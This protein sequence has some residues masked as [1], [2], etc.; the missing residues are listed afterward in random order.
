MIVPKLVNRLPSSVNTVS[1]ERPF[2]GVEFSSPMAELPSAVVQTGLPPTRELRLYEVWYSDS[3]STTSGRHRDW[4]Y[5]YDDEALFAW[6]YLPQQGDLEEQTYHAYRTL[7]ELLDALEFLHLVKVWHYIPDLCAEQ[8]GLRRYRLFCRGRVRALAQHV[9]DE[10]LNAATVVGTE[11]AS[12]V[13]YF[14]ASRYPTVP[15]DNPRQ[16]RAY[17]YPIYA[18]TERPLFARACLLRNDID[19]YLYVS[20]TASIVGHSSQQ[21]GDAGGQT[22]T[23]ISNFLHVLEQAARV[24]SRFLAVNKPSIQR[25]N[26]YCARREDEQTIRRCAQELLSRAHYPGFYCGSICRPELLVEID[27]VVT[28]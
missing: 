26:F 7:L 27:A 11:A 17:Q 2:V 8:G 25:M 3:T 28:A 9:S 21:R 12:G 18:R 22:Q 16:T 4:S 6:L 14:I 20:G 13:F 5:F 1:G 10:Q 15:I 23:A 24:D 19:A